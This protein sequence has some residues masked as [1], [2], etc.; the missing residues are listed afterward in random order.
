MTLSSVLEQEVADL[1]RRLDDLT[2][3][4][5][6]NAVADAFLLSNHALVRPGDFCLI[7]GFPTRLEHV[8][9]QGKWTYFNGRNVTEPFRIPPSDDI[10]RLY[11]AAE[12]VEIVD[13]AVADAV[14]AELEARGGS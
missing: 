2:E 13:K 4:V 10:Q 6:L 3:R 8:N 1:R 5:R 12:V 9:S 7:D 14:A 11:T